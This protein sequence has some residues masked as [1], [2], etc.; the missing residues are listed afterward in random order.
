MVW[1]VGR[2]SPRPFFMRGVA[3]VTN[4]VFER[5]SISLRRGEARLSENAWWVLFLCVE[6]LPRRREL[7]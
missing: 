7:A 4:S 2:D 5:A 1:T 6:L 3:Q